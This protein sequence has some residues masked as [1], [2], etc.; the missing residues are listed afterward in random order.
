MEGRSL[1]QHVQL[2]LYDRLRKPASASSAPGLLPVLFFGDINTARVATLGL[3]PSLYWYLDR[4]GSEL[5]GVNRR[6]ETLRSLGAI[7]RSALTDAQ[8][9]QALETTKGYF[10]PS[11]AVYWQW[12]RSISRVIEGLGFSY[13]HRTAAHL[14]LVQETTSPAWSQLQ[15]EY[16]DEADALLEQDQPFLRWQI[17]TF[18]IEILDCNGRSPL[19]A[20]IELLIGEVL[21]TEVVS[22]RRKWTIAYADI[23]AGRL[24]IVGWNIPLTRPPGLTQQG[25]I[26][27][28]QQLRHELQRHDLFHI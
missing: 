4:K 20:V 10:D 28:G 5:V 2:Q 19:D 7:D 17:E 25:Q 27:M 1:I 8:C 14:D 24:A 13:E 12:F 26:E 21:A 23:G 11:R 9:E 3:N 6:F 15:R 18:P 22:G 16:P